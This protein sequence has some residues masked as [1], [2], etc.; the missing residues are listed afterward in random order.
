MITSVT[1]AGHSAWA[2][3]ASQTSAGASGFDAIL[4]AFRKEIVKTPAERA[5]DAVLAKHKLSEES[6]RAL[7]PEKRATID[8][9]IAEAVRRVTE[10]RAQTPDSYQD[11]LRRFG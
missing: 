7:P 10:K 11:L 1:G 5:R 8:K 3:G 6:Y 2:T 9:E 4:D